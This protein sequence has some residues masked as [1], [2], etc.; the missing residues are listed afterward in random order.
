[1]SGDPATREGGAAERRWPAGGVPLPSVGRLGVALWAAVLGVEAALLVAYF[2]LAD[3]T[4]LRLGYVLAPFV[5]IDA[6]IWAVA[7]TDPPPAPRRRRLAAGTLATGYFLLLLA[8]TGLLGPGSGGSVVWLELGGGSP[9]WGPV[10]R[11]GGALVSVTFVPFR[12]VGYL[13]LAYLVYVATL[14]ASAAALSG[15]LG[16]AACVSCGFSVVLSLVAGLTGGSAAALGAVYAAS[17][18]V[19]T[20]VFLLAVLLLT[21]G[22]DAG[23]RLA[24]RLR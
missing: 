5:W 24:K 20:G 2:S 4:V 21:L 12:V 22:P 15:A 14:E 8:V 23:R 16:L 19:S 9:G 3:A 6:G 1:M 18:E 17:V 7:R 10:I 13:A 11:Y